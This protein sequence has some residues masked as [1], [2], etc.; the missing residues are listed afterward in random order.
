MA[1]VLYMSVECSIFGNAPSVT[2]TGHTVLSQAIVRTGHLT[3]F[4]EISEHGNGDSVF[5]ASPRVNSF[6]R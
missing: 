6:I 4:I 5:R 2:N 3:K 1:I